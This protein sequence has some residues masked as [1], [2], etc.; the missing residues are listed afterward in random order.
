MTY[1]WNVG[2]EQE[3]K[4]KQMAAL[5]QLNVISLLADVA[6]SLKK[7]DAVD[8]ILPLFIES[9]EEGDASVPSLVR[10]QVNLVSIYLIPT[11]L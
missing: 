2:L 8:L 6:V 10:L 9:L 4:E 11:T 7:S 5:T 3:K 1:A